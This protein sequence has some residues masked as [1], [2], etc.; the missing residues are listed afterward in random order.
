M[1]AIRGGRLGLGA[2]LP[3]DGDLKRQ[4]LSANEK[5][6]QQL[7]GKDYK[8]L[9]AKRRG[10]GLPEDGL[11]LGSKPRPA[12][13][14]RVVREDSEDEGGRSSLGKSKR[15]RHAEGEEANVEARANEATRAVKSRSDEA[16]E[17]PRKASNYLDQ[18]L[19]EKSRK[20]QH[21]QKRKRKRQCDA[22]G[23]E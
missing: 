2:K 19:A 1:S 7:L 15:K 12:V 21:N 16:S 3:A 20:K 14:E 10:K 18:V 6:R 11:I 13:P 22:A 4:D 17:Q 9:Q 8:K 23:L 5:L